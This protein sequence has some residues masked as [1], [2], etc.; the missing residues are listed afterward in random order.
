MSRLRR[1]PTRIRQEPAVLAEIDEEVENGSSQSVCPSDSANQIADTQA[2]RNTGD[3]VQQVP[4]SLI[5]P[6]AQIMNNYNQTPMHP[7][8]VKKLVPLFNPDETTSNLWLDVLENLKKIY[9]WPDS[10]VL[11]YAV[12]R[13]GEV[14]RLWYEAVRVKIASWEDFKTELRKGFPNIVDEA[15]VHF[16]LMKRLKRLDES[17]EKYVYEIMAIGRTVNLSESAL[18]KYVVHGIQDI[19]L[20]AMLSMQKF[21]S[22]MEIIAC[23]KRFES[24]NV[25]KH[26]QNFQQSTVDNRWVCHNCN[27]VGHISRNC[28][29]TAV[30]CSQCGRS[31]HLF[32]FCRGGAPNHFNQNLDLGHS[33][34]T[35]TVYTSKFGFQAA[36]VNRGSTAG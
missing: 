11:H 31:G 26:P 2:I 33:K 23:L 34:P 17:Y 20:Q 1:S 36:D 32:K 15:D 9:A 21:D 6:A 3:E 35:T 30:K 8:D 18:V 10:S 13:L 29:K 28:M 16:R 14:P 22:V 24:L 7:D 25:M 4:M 19:S 12:T 27:E 5:S